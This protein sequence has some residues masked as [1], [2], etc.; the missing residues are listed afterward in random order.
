MNVP[1]RQERGPLYVILFDMLNMKVEDQATARLQLLRFIRDKPEGARFA[2]FVLSDGLRLIQ[3]FTAD[4]VQLFTA[5]DPR[6]PRPHV[7]RLFLY[8]DN[9]G[10]G[11]VSVV[12]SAFSTIARFLDGLP[13]RK[14]V[15][16]VTG[17]LSSSI[18]PTGDSED[19]AVTYSDEIKRAVDA[20]ARSQVAVYPVDVRGVM[21]T[22]VGTSPG[23]GK[24]G[25]AMM[26]T[27]DSS[28]MEASYAT[29]EEV[30]R[31]TGGHAFYSSN[32]LKEALTQATETGSEYYTLSYSPTNQNYDGRMRKIGVELSQR[33][34]RLAYRRAYYADTGYAD[35]DSRR[36][37]K[38]HASDPEA[39][40]RKP[41]DSL[42]AN[43]QHGAPL[44]HDLLFR[45]HI[46][47]VGAP[48]KATPAQM[49]NL[50]KQLAFFGA[51]PKN[52]RAKALPPVPLQT[53][54]IDFA[55][56]VQRPKGADASQAT[57]LEFAAVF[58]DAEGQML[59]ATVQSALE[60]TTTGQ[61]E[62]SEKPVYH[63][64]QQIDAPLNAASIRIAVRDVST[65]RV[66]AMEVTLPLAPEPQVQA[67]APDD[68]RLADR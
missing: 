25:A 33:G 68:A 28:V 43:M 38:G 3:G 27:S 2:I 39:A 61:N 10:V 46:Q 42:I 37:G 24:G 54:A 53:Y 16:W 29:E 20:M 22:H 19:E 15:I 6:T 8:A 5:M 58:Y 56:M 34:Y 67:S 55:V 26:T 65:D 45:A 13:G 62:A 31:A 14:N 7:P 64:Q 50:E 40:P 41:V 9:F 63:A 66:G 60:G 12:A 36:R 17:S 23:M 11:E 18:L 44:A 1:T 21:T 4:Q 47:R 52:G 51:R 32:D 59:S 57:A 35:T 30:A 48:A 49:S